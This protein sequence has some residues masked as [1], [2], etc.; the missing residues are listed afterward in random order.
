ML[1]GA[2]RS[3]RMGEGAHKLLLPFDGRPLVARAVEAACASRA[4]AVA[5]VLGHRADAVRAALPAGRYVATVNSDYATGMASSLVR[6]L[7]ALRAT[8]GDRLAGVVVG[9]ADQPLVP[10]ALFDAVIAEGLAHPGAIVSASYAG[11]RGTPVW[12]PA[13][14]FDELAAVAGDEG[15][16]SIIASHLDWLRLVEWPDARAGLDVDRPEDF[17]RLL[18]GTTGD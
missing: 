4:D 9:L 5:V 15:G 17:A 7:A 14:L 13:A 3:S 16:R 10:P 2:G 8:A 6:G 11:Q 18:Q 12:F 1:L